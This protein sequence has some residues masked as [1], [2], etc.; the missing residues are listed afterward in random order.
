[1]RSA[2]PKATTRSST[3]QLLR[4]TQLSEKAKSRIADAHNKSQRQRWFWNLLNISQPWRQVVKPELKTATYKHA[5]DRIY[6]DAAW[7]TL[8]QSYNNTFPERKRIHK[9]DP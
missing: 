6:K 4:L 1:M 3:K 7:R 9:K 2:Y 8:T 5:A